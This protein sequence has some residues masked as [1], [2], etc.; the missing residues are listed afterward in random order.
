MNIKTEFTQPECDRFRR[1]C[2]F[3]D[4]EL[5]VFDLRVKNKTVVQIQLL[6]AEQNLPM[7]ESTINRRIRSIKRKIY[8]IM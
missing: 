7:S 8:K 5:A 6:L 1:E 3:S 2:Y 4:E